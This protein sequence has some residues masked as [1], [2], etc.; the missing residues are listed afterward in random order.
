MRHHRLLAFVPLATC[1]I[2][3]GLGTI[4]DGQNQIIVAMV[5]W[6]GVVIHGLLAITLWSVRLRMRFGQL[7]LIAGLLH[8]IVFSFTVFPSA[9]IAFSIMVAVIYAWLLRNGPRQNLLS[10]VDS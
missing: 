8:L 5:F 9:L 1:I 2:L 10:N 4:S 3:F 6:G 7:M